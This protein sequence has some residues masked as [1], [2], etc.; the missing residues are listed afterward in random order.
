MKINT[1]TL[2]IST[3]FPTI[4]G[5]PDDDADE[6]STVDPGKTKTSVG[7]PSNW[8][9]LSPKWRAHV[10]AFLVRRVIDSVLGEGGDGAQ[11]TFDAFRELTGWGKK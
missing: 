4:D 10:L 3:S 2:S 5:V 7:W 11:E 9:L 1:K 8:H 6:V